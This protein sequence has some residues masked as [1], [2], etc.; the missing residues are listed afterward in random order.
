[1]AGS[2]NVQDFAAIQAKPLV[3]SCAQKSVAL[4][5]EGARVRKRQ[6]CPLPGTSAS[7]MR[8]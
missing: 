6:K 1:L 8:G 3:R 4:V 5:P 7:T 2:G